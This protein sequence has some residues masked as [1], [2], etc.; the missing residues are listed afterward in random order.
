MPKPGTPEWDAAIAEHD[1][2]LR[3]QFPDT[4]I[5]EVISAKD[6]G[7]LT[8]RAFGELLERWVADLLSE[9]EPAMADLVGGA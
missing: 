9:P 8:V 6:E 5:T 7:K 4:D 2:A 3:E 1:R